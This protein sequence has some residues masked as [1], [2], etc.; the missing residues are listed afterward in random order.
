M[1]AEAEQ[2]AE[3]FQFRGRFVL[4]GL[5]LS[6]LP[7]C[8]FL[9]TLN[10]EGHQGPTWLDFLTLPAETDCGS[11]EFLFPHS[12][13]A[14]FGGLITKLSP[15][16]SLA[17]LGYLTKYSCNIT[18]RLPNKLYLQYCPSDIKQIIDVSAFTF[19]KAMWVFWNH[20]LARNIVVRGPKY[21]QIQ[22]W[23][24]KLALR[25]EKFLPIPARLLLSKTGP[26]F[27]P[28]LY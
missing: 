25:C 11:D 22:R 17:Q 8:H 14:R 21:V 5:Q 26:P 6:L 19:V 2:I 3:H 1:A 15:V 4:P 24:K 13:H 20:A 7:Q 12:W 28:P 18:Y 9:R 10:Q 16:T 27:S 23:D